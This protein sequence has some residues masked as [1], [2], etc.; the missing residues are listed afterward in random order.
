M[1][2]IKTAIFV[3]AWRRRC[4]QGG[5]FATVLRRGDGDAGM[6]AVRV[7]QRGEP[8]R[9]WME[10]RDINGERAWRDLTRGGASE[11]E[12]DRLLEREVSFDP[13]LWIV[14]VEDREGRPFLQEKLLDDGE[15]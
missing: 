11:Q 3:D 15:M 13:D 10:T 4:Q 1:I 8:M 2:R 14:E 6:V 5:A 12:A 9:V 7:Y